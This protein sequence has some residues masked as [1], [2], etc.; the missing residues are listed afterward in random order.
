MIALAA[1]GFAQDLPAGEAKEMVEKTCTA[2]HDATQIVEKKGDKEEWTQTVKNMQSY[3]AT[4][5]EKDFPVIVDY[6]VKNFG[7]GGA[8]PAAAAGGA[9]SAADEAGLA[10]GEGRD[11]VAAQCT[12][13]HDAE[14]IK[15]SKKSKEE[16]SEILNS[17]VSYG[18]KLTNAE[19]STVM[20]YLAKA[21]GK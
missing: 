15:G 18:A 13:C 1:T 7:K 4:V 17:M 21:Y 10:A 9:K 5:S 11:I 6:L 20:E 2:C 14:N 3:G 19:F 8:A 16:W 12:A